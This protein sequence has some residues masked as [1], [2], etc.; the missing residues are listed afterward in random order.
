MSRVTVSVFENNNFSCNS[1]SQA[2]EPL[3]ALLIQVTLFMHK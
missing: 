2:P 1:I 3:Y